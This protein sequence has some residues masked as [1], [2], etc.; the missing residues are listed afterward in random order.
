M[1]LR[2]TSLTNKFYMKIRNI[3]ILEIDQNKKGDLFGRLMSD[4]FHSLGYDEPRLNIHKS[5]REIDVSAFHRTESKIA[6]AE[7]KAHS[8]KIGGQILTNL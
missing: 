1:L 5:G 3:E 8:E 6:V 2:N 7:C 4:L